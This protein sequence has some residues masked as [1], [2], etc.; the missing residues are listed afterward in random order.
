MNKKLNNAIKHA[1][2]TVEEVQNDSIYYEDFPDWMEGLEQ[3][4]DDGWSL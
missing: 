1:K 4:Y 3:L 2:I